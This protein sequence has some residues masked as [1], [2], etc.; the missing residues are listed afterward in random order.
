MKHPG[1]RLLVSL[2]VLL[3]VVIYGVYQDCVIRYSHAPQLFLEP[4]QSIKAECLRRFI[5]Y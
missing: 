4:H 1:R 5:P 3:A 2:L